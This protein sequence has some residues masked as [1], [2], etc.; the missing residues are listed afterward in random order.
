MLG[1]RYRFINE[2]YRECT[3]YLNNPDCGWYHI[4]TIYP[5]NAVDKDELYSV[6]AD[7]EKLAFLFINI[8]KYRNE[9]PDEEV[10]VRLR[11]IFNVFVSRRMHMIVRAAY[12]NSGLGMNKEPAHIN[13]VREHMKFF[14]RI[15]Q[16]YSEYILTLQGLFVGSWGEMHS[17]KYLTNDA[18][19]RE[20]AETM[21]KAV[22]GKCCIAVRRPDQY[23]ILKGI[24]PVSRLALF[25]DA[26]GASESDMNT[27]GH[28]KNVYADYAEE[29]IR[30]IELRWQYGSVHSVPNGG[31]VLFGEKNTPGS[32]AIKDFE[33]M[34]ITY[35][36]SA[37][38]AV[39]L[40][41]WRKE[42]YTGRDAYNGLS[43]YDYIGTHLGYRFVVRNAGLT[44]KRVLFADIENVGFAALY[45]EA[46]CVLELCSDTSKT[47]RLKFDYDMRNIKS[48]QKKRIETDISGYIVPSER[49]S[50][51]ISMSSKYDNEPIRFANNSIEDKMFL[52]KI[53]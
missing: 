17:S 30:R 44:R 45:K 18:A 14:G 53:Y 49:Y 13:I 15:F 23:R 8:G 42:K 16:E 51:Y 34:H 48:G 25:N 50:V 12:D 9:I 2:D 7:D 24:I 11:E 43:V 27:Y 39:Q 19:L 6:I 46:E 22:D 3:Q 40:N 47:V 20:L 21:Y 41:A 28:D 38:D 36:N 52:G 4:Y 5:Q 33:D 32:D 26:I 10:L 31:E 35:L 37:Y 1:H 29:E